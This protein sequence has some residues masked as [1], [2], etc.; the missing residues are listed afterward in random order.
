MAGKQNR[1]RATRSN[2]SRNELDLIGRVRRDH[3]IGQT[4]VKVSRYGFMLGFAWVV[5]NGLSEIAT[6]LA[7]KVTIADIRAAFSLDTGDDGWVVQLLTSRTFLEVV[8]GLLA[9]VCFLYARAQKKRAEETI[10]QLAPFRT[11]Y[12]QLLDEGRTSSGLSSNGNT[13]P[14]ERI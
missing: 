14:D 10:E 13:P 9:A 8:E 6:A 2:F 11:R 4:I 1:S 3:T 7:G 5:M 12:E